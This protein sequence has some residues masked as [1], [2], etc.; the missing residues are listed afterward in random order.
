MSRP[1]LHDFSGRL[2]RRAAK[3]WRGARALVRTPALGVVSRVSS[4][5]LVDAR[6]ATVVS[7]TSYSTRLRSV[8]LTIESIGRGSVRPGRIILWVDPDVVVDDLP[9]E[10]Q[11]LRRRGLEIASSPGRYG[12]HTKYFPYVMSEAPHDALLVTADDDSLYPR[13]WLASLQEAAAGSEDVVCF[14]AHRVGFDPDG[15]LAPYNS[16][17]P[18]TET[19]PSPLNFATGVSGVGYP[20]AFLN[21]LQALGDA[22]ADTC[23]K[24]DDVWLHYAAVRGGRRIRQLGPRPRKF[25]EVLSTQVMALHRGNTGQAANDAQIA[26]TYSADVIETLRTASVAA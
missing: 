9:V 25:P 12:P 4:R 21:E 24:A 3:T 16:W 1:L 26:A 8:H 14:R 7:L 17:S 19:G 5:P 20:P 23:A 15:G 6:N 11:R 22:F 13:W 2:S 18:V 10:L